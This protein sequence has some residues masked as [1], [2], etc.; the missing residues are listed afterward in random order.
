M[1][2]V[3]HAPI[4][5]AEELIE[6]VGVRAE[7]WLITQMPFAEQACRVAAFFKRLSGGRLGRE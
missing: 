5:H 4:E 2:I 7:L 3:I 6:A 1:G